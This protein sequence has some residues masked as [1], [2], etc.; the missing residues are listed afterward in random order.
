MRYNSSRSAPLIPSLGRTFL[1]LRADALASAAGTV[2]SADGSRVGQAAEALSR[3]QLSAVMR[4]PR[5]L[6]S[7][8]PPARGSPTVQLSLAS[9][10]PRP[11]RSQKRRSEFDLRQRADDGSSRRSCD[12]T[13]KVALL[14][15]YR[16]HG[17]LGLKKPAFPS[18][19]GGCS[20]PFIG[21]SKNLGSAPTRRVDI[22]ALA[23]PL[24]R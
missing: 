10:Q 22:R 1:R 14:G 13:L 7:A 2:H 19:N 15:A 11:N 6:R 12:A 8:A 4:K 20:L 16:Q 24:L 23:F 21:G 18:G 9:P 17:F 5:R 3:S